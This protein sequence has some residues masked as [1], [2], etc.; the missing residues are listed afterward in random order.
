MSLKLRFVNGEIDFI[1][2]M[3]L[4]N[5]PNQSKPGIPF[6]LEPIAE[7]LAKKLFYRGAMLTPVTCMTGGRS[8]RW[9]P[10][11]FRTTSL[12]GYSR[13]EWME[14]RMHSTP[15]VPQ[16]ARSSAGMRFELPP[17]RRLKR[18]LNSPSGS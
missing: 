14:S 11:S 10:M 5:L 7:V 4:L 9:H 3:S 17:S 1:V 2:A 8:M 12:P 13:I 18:P 15:C 6:E 16:T